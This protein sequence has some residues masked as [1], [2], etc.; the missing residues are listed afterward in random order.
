MTREASAALRLASG[1]GIDTLCALELLFRAVA[2]LS[3]PLLA[4]RGDVFGFL[5]STGVLFRGGAFLLEDAASLFCSR[6]FSFG[7]CSVA[8]GFGPPRPRLDLGLR[9]A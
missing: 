8:L 9:L 5:G 1:V 3:C 6:R 7:E 2:L 4:L